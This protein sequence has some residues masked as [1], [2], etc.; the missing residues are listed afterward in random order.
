MTLNVILMLVMKDTE[1]NTNV[2]YEWHFRSNFWM[3]L[4][5][6][7]KKVL[8]DSECNNKVNSEWHWM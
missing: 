7:L 8:N 1:C 4:N 3:T 2:C 5:M 6:I